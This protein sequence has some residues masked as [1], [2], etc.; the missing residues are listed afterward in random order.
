MCTHLWDYKVEVMYTTCPRTLGVCLC[1]RHLQTP[2]SQVH[3]NLDASIATW[4]SILVVAEGCFLVQL[5]VSFLTEVNLNF[6]RILPQVR[7]PK[8]QLSELVH[9]PRLPLAVI[10]ICINVNLNSTTST[11]SATIVLVQLEVVYWRVL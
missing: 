8:L 11:S 4:Q 3:G 7:W 2:H 10:K 9:D 1:S 5:E 6:H